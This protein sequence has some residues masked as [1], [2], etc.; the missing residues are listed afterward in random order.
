[1]RIDVKFAYE[2]DKHPTAYVEVNGL[3]LGG[4]KRLRGVLRGLETMIREGQPKEK[5][6]EEQKK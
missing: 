5:T 6:K 2:T 3:G 4:I 1:M